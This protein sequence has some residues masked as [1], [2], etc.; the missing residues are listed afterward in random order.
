MSGT[1]TFKSVERDG[2]EERAELYDS[3]TARMT[4][5]A[6]EALLNAAQVSPGQLVL[7]VCCGTGLVS[8]SAVA[9]GGQVTGIDFSSAMIE[10]ARGKD[11]GAEF[12]V[13]DAEELPFSDASFDCV[14]TNYGHY[15]LPDPDRAI[16]EAARVLKPFGRYAFTTWC[17]PDRSPG[18]KLIFGTITSIADMDVGLP[19]GPD[20]FRLAKPDEVTAVMQNAG[21]D[22]I[23]INEFPSKIECGADELVDFLDKAT[24]RATMLLKRQKPE[25]RARI[26]AAL[27]EGAKEFIAGGV[28][29]LPLPS[30]VIAGKKL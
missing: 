6:I 15:H 1:P 21:F 14:I 26:E 23:E 20:P 2:W 13:G 29:S 25:V 30:L 7:D 3:Y 24:V 9:R 4:S 11:L 28:L 22:K 12:R 17:G 10:T 16:Y 27:N 19:P 8:A 5:P 18:I